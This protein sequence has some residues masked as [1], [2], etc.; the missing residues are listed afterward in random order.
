M[1]A[2]GPAVVWGI[3]GFVIGALPAFMLAGP[4][5][6]ADGPF[7]ER[8]LALALYALAMLVVGI[9]GGA[10]AGSKRVA[11]AI[12]LALPVLPMLLLLETSGAIEMY[13]LGA[14]FV[15]VAFAAAWA[16]TLLGE[17]LTAAVLARR[18]R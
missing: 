6:F 9:G 4:A 7:V 3:L 14:G 16:G 10:T 13:L 1:N 17:R 12:G 11:I 18:N 8:L 5:F 15:V 2:R